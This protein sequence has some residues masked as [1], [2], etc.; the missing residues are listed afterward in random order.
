MV[1]LCTFFFRQLNA[2]WSAIINF[3]LPSKTHFMCN[4]LLVIYFVFVWVSIH[5]L[6]RM[7][8]EYMSPEFHIK[9]AIEYVSIPEKKLFQ[10]KGHRIEC[11]A[12]INVRC[13]YNIRIIWV[14]FILFTFIVYS[15]FQKYLGL[16]ED[17]QYKAFHFMMTWQRSIKECMSFRIVIWLTS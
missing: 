3:T 14:T 15:N 11:F 10:S 17:S 9:G 1:F 6:L 13:R 16:L 8:N 5:T 4:K 2:L 12:I 7:H